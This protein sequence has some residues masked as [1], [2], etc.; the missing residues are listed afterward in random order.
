[1]AAAVLNE[2]RGTLSLTSGLRV[3]AGRYLH[4]GAVPAHTHGFAELVVV[5]AGSGVHLS[6]AGRRELRVGDAVLLRPGLWHSYEDCDGLELYNC[7]FNPELLQRELAWMRED[8]LLGRLLWAN[9]EEV[10]GRLD[11][12]A[13]AECVEHLDALAKLDPRSTHRAD[14]VGRLSLV[15]GLA[16]R[17]LVEPEGTGVR[18]A[19]LAAARLL[20]D[21]PARP[22]TV[23]ALGAALHL[24]PGYLARVFK[25]ATGL[26][27]M[28]YLARHRVETAAGLL[29]HTDLPVGTIAREVGWADPNL[30]A[31][32]FR[33]HLGMSP[34]AY[35]SRFTGHDKAMR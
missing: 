16:V 14:V 33:A 20:E 7:C 10:E 5:L 26:P 31:R 19:V 1:M 18:P 15:L 24:S 17:A 35:R 13:L 22:W 21:Q 32:R 11:P 25:E 3:H 29:L 28:A 8:P 4:D 30:F 34:T 6:R 12:E 9:A 2:S 27:P 23:D